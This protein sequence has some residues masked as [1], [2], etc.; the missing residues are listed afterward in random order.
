MKQVLKAIIVFF[1]IALL[2]NC[3]G[4][5]NN[6]DSIPFS[7]E[8]LEGLWKISLYQ[9]QVRNITYD[10][11]DILM[12]FDDSSGIRAFNDAATTFGSYETG[13]FEINGE[14]IW[15]LQIGLD[16]TND[17]H[18]VLDD[19]RNNWHVKRVL[20]DAAKIEF[21]QALNPAG[22]LEILHLTRV[23]DTND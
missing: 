10:G 3:Y 17:A 18:D 14:P 7:P 11:I 21:E 20:L 8:Q 19:I 22:Q 9:D 1:L 6:E 16:I 12:E 13:Q 2:F 4:E 23:T 15:E 5:D